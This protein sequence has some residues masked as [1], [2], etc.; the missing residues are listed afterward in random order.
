MTY[1]LYFRGRLLGGEASG[2]LGDILEGFR[3]IRRKGKNWQKKIDNEKKIK[4]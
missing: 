4:N 2:G 1:S 3:G